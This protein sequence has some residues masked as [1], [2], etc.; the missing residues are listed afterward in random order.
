MR[1]HFLDLPGQFLSGRLPARTGERGEP[2]VNVLRIRLQAYV[3]GFHLLQY[4][5]LLIPAG[6]LGTHQRP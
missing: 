4:C 5:Q 6:K 2:F 1:L 3:L